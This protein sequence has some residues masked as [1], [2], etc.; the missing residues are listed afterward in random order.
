MSSSTGMM[1]SAALSGCLAA[2]PGR[3]SQARVTGALLPRGTFTPCD[4][5]ARSRAIEIGAFIISCVCVARAPCRWERARRRRG[6]RPRLAPPV[7][8]TGCWL[9]RLC[10]VRSTREAAGRSPGP[11]VPRTQWAQVRAPSR[12][13]WA[14]VNQL[15]WVRW[16][17]VCAVC[18]GG[19][20]Y[21]VVTVVLRLLYWC[22]C[23]VSFWKLRAT[24]IS[25]GC[26]WI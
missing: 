22:R 26:N 3:S 11:G 25:V 2:P 20:L 16:R 14:R 19:F 17:R 10:A 8:A 24:G 23:T 5:P 13:H 15:C 18:I 7:P 12:G 1:W 21:I 6:G 9:P 4:W